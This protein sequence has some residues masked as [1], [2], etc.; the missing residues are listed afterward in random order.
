MQG[1]GTHHIRLVLQARVVVDRRAAH[2][3]GGLNPALALL[4]HMPGLMGQVR[5]LTGRHMGGKRQDLTPGFA[6]VR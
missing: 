5:A 2:V 1:L 4:H 3:K 6:L